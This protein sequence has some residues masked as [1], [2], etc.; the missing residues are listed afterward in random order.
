[1]DFS[2]LIHTSQP[3]EI[4]GRKGL[5][6]PESTAEPGIE[7]ECIGSGET[8]HVT[9][10][11]NYVSTASGRRLFSQGLDLIRGLCLLIQLVNQI[12]QIRQPC[13]YLCV[14]MDG[15]PSEALKLLLAQK[16]YVYAALIHY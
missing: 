13:A 1:M 3:N 4:P 9:H 8:F 7:V 5:R 16:T 10:V 14:K 15:R 11:F 6:P 2:G 12:L